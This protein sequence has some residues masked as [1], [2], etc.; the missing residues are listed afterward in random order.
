MSSVVYDPTKRSGKER[1]FH[2]IMF[3]VIA[4]LLTAPVAAWLM[5]HS[6]TKMGMLAIMFA[7]IASV[8]NVVFNFLF[9]LAQRRMCFKRT[10]KIRMLHA[11]LFELSLI[12]VLVPVAAWWLSIS[13]LEAFILDLGFIIF[14]LPYTF[15]YNYGYDVIRERIFTK[16]LAKQQAGIEVLQ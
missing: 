6:I 5:G 3:E 15:F 12:A 16:R 4:T 10:A 1:A 7:T 14:F 11:F 13:F 9:D 2:A 8:C